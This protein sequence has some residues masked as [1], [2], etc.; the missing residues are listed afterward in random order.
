MG[1]HP[2][3]PLRQAQRP[4]ILSHRFGRIRRATQG[5]SVR[6]IIA[7]D[8]AECLGAGTRAELVQVEKHFDIAPTLIGQ[9]RH[10]DRSG[11]DVPDVDIT[12]GQDTIIWPNTYVQGT[13]KIGA[14]CVI[15]PSV[16][17]R[18]AVIPDGAIVKP[19]THIDGS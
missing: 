15:G 3:L 13:T 17:L 9:R 4:R 10:L 7:E 2:N 16:V 12:I 8:S 5:R 6:A 14:D 19:F 1:Q 18:N 11:D